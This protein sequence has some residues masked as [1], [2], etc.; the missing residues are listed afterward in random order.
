M[1]K[2][3]GIWYAKKSDAPNLGSLTCFECSGPNDMLRKYSGLKADYNKLPKYDKAGETKLSLLGGSIFIAAD[4]GE[5]YT[6][7]AT[8]KTWPQTV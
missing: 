5:I 2:V 1:V 8:N 4:T 3:D 6:Y 7:V